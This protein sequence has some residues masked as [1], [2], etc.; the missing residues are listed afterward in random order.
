MKNGIYLVL[1][2][3][4]LVIPF[5][6]AYSMA[7]FGL[8]T[9]AAREHMM[10]A[11]ASLAISLLI[12]VP[13]AIVAL[14]NKWLAEGIIA[15]ANLLQAIPSLA[16]I[17]LVI[18]LLGIGFAPA[19]VVIVLRALLPIIKN[20]YVGLSS[21]DR[22]Y[23][24]SARGIG[25]SDWQIIWHIRF[26]NAW[27]AF[28]A[29]VKFSSIM[30]NSVAILTAYIGTGGFGSVIRSGFSNFNTPKILAGVLPVMGIAIATDLA[31]SWMEGR[32]SKDE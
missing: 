20:T 12:S 29:G 4:I 3:P 17:A 19:I 1:M 5:F 2:I 25:L 28:F 16:V 23:I 8:I 13:L 32:V 26:P 30:A 14:Y 22:E 9:R 10:L 18:P 21:V 15:F 31:L 7:D 6:L 11:Y 24:E 27:P